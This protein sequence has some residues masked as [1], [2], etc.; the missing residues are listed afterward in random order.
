MV[1]VFKSFAIKGVKRESVVKWCVMFE[2]SAPLQEIRRMLLKDCKGSL[3]F[4]G[5]YQKLQK[6]VLHVYYKVVS[7]P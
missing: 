4:H 3:N 5:L 6:K 7:G 2:T 1:Q